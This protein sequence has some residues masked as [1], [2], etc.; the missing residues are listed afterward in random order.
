[1]ISTKTGPKRDDVWSTARVSTQITVVE[2]RLRQHPEGGS[3]AG[4][5]C[6]LLRGRYPGGYGRE[7]YSNARVEGKHHPGG[8]DPLDRVGRAEPSN[9]KDGSGAVYK[10]SSVQSPSFHLK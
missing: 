10:P 2:Y 8:Y 5:K 6:H 3:P 1:M 9:Y 7:Q 4:G